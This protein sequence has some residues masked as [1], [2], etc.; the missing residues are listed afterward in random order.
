MGVTRCVPADAASAGR[1]PDITL[2]PFD[3][4]DAEALPRRFFSEA[5][6]PVDGLSFCCY[7]IH[8]GRCPVR[9]YRSPVVLGVMPFQNDTMFLPDLTLPPPFNSP[10]DGAGRRREGEQGLLHRGRFSR[11]ARR[12]VSYRVGIRREAGRTVNLSPGVAVL[13]T[14]AEPSEWGLELFSHAGTRAPGAGGILRG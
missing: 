7:F 13:A 9:D 1:R 8:S 11:D 5:S 10:A 6:S 12:G 2:C 14:T 3:R 4:D